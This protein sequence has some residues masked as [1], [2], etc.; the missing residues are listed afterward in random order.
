MA[1]PRVTTPSP[2]HMELCGKDHPLAFVVDIAWGQGCHW[3][4]PWEHRLIAA[5]TL[6]GV[7][8]G[9]Q[10]FSVFDESEQCKDAQEAEND[11]CIFH[12]ILFFKVM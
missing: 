10:V 11:C 5:D 1:A 9:G 4:K 7:E 12:K 8:V 2:A 3:R 6:I